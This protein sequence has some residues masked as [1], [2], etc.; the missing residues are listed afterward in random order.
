MIKVGDRVTYPSVSSAGRV[1]IKGGIG[2]VVAIKPDTFGK[3]SRQI[4]VVSAHGS[5]F[6][7]FVSA[8]ETVNRGDQN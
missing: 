1:M 5:K 8:L 6:E 4:A 3:S 2:D 7:V